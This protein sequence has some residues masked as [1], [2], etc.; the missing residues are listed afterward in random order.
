MRAGEE[1]FNFHNHDMV[2]VAVAIPAVRVANPV[3]NGE[4]TVTLMRQAAERKA[5]LVLF[6]E[7]GLPGVF[8]RGP[9]S[10]ARHTRRMRRGAG[11][12]SSRPA[13]RSR[14]SPSSASRSRSTISFSTAPPSSIAD[15]SSA[16][17]PKTYSAQLP[18]VLRDAPVHV[19]R[20][21]RAR[22]N[23][24][25]R[26]IRDSLRRAPALRR[27]G[28]AAAHVSRRDLRR[29]VG[30]DSAVVLCGAGRRDG[31]AESFGA[32]TSRSARPISAARWSQA[33]RPD[34]SRPISTRAPARE[35]RPPISPGTAR[36]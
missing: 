9:V 6:P 30:A 18:R 36:R 10:A 7:L 19:R 4:Q 15:A 8:L 2:R 33:S 25:L 27:R 31:A 11:A 13:V 32:R 22:R 29:L 17:C 14:S 23:R 26:P 28:T 20:C 1:F 3:F 12:G 35:S 21:R 24:A 16:W 5:A 34:A